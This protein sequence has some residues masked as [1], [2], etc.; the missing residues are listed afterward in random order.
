MNGGRHWMWRRALEIAEEAERLESAFVRYLGPKD[1]AVSW[2]PPVDVYECDAGVVVHIALPGVA[3]G[4]IEISLEDAAV[5][6]SATR[7]VS[8]PPEGSFIR[9][10]EIPHGRFVRRVALTG[11]TRIAESEYRNGCLELRLVPAGSGQ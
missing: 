11:P 9:R 5:V 3:P 10:L 8:C 6:V 4:E 2:E 7:L 1:S